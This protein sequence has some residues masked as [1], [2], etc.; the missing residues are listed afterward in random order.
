LRIRRW[1]WRSRWRLDATQHP[2]TLTAEAKKIRARL[3]QAEDAR[4]AEQAHVTQLTA[5]DGKAGGAQKN[6]L[7]DQLKLAH[8]QLEL[9][10]DEVDDAKQEFDQAGGDLQDRIEAMAKEHEAA[11][12][13]SDAT[14]LAVTSPIE[15]HGLIQRFEQWS[16][17]HQKQLQLWRAK[18][19]AISMAAALA[20]QHEALRQSGAESNASTGSG[21][22]GRSGGSAGT[23]SAEATP[24]VTLETTQHRAADR[25]TLATLDKRVDYEPNWPATGQ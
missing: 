8:A 6:A 11:S 17:L 23:C 24:F 22:S 18:Q 4:A 25:K 16:A 12:Q 19:D 2:P 15:P 1:I 5:A 3:A 10:Q 20:R 13:V 14:K 9:A 21:A 7:D